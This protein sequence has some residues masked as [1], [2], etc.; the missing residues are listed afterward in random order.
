MSAEHGTP[1]LVPVGPTAALVRG[2]PTGVARDFWNGMIWRPS[3]PRRAP[4]LVPVGPTAA[5][6]RGP[7][8]GGVRDALAGRHRHMAAETGPAA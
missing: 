5:L 8:T 3:P 6:V 7:L 2:S 4:G 1:G